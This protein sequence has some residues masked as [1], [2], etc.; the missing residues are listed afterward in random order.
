ME[1]ISYI[2]PANKLISYLF[3]AWTKL[4]N[5]YFHSIPSL[6]NLLFFFY[7]ILWAKWTM[8]VLVKQCH[9]KETTYIVWVEYFLIYHIKPPV[10][11]SM[12][13]KVSFFI[14]SSGKIFVSKVEPISHVQF[15]PR[16]CS[17]QRHHIHRWC[18][19]SSF[20]RAPTEIGCSVM[21]RREVLTINCC[22]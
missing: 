10:N 22:S 6:N 2:T 5:S 1:M 19:P 11:C 16:G 3:S 4:M 15:C 14:S 20:L 9:A 13:A 7:C 8:K 21:R 17:R 12:I 18:Q